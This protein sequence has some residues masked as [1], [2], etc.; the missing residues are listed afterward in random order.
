MAFSEWTH[1]MLVF[2]IVLFLVFW[3]KKELSRVPIKGSWI[4]FPVLLLAIVLYWAGY[5]AGLQYVGYLSIMTFIAGFVLW[6]L[7]TRF[8]GTVFFIWAFLMFAWPFV[9]LDQYIA[10]PLRLLMSEA[11][12][13]VL[14]AI[15]VPTIRE[16]TAILSAPDIRT[17]LQKGARFSVDVADPCSGIRSL[18]ALTMI[19]A[20][21]GIFSFRKSWQ[22]LVLFLI[23]FP[24]AIFGNLC[25]ILMLTFGTIGFGSRF[26]IGTLEEPSWFHEGAG[27][28]V[29]IAALL[30]VLSVGIFIGRFP[31]KAISTQ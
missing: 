30:G 13:R 15:H 2:P 31:K 24:F 8:F 26:A 28:I 6:F 7:G 29:Y 1:G 12:A 3:K 10:F 14:N 5:I 21:Y 18:F 11:S 22:I 27:F 4:G 16:G 25:R 23:A 20:L 19:S 9:F 17:A